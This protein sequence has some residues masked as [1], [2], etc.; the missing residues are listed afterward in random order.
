LFFLVLSFEKER[1]KE[2]LYTPLLALSF[3]KE[4]AKENF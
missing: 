3:E 2:N 4:S 1:T